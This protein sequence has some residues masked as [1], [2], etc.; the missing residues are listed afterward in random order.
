MVEVVIGVR[1]G[2]HAKSRCGEVLTPDDRARL[3]EAMLED[4][5]EAVAGAPAIGRLWVVTPT[6]ELAR[7]AA[8]R[9][10]EIIHQP[11]DGDLNDA[12]A[13]AL[14]EIGERAPYD[15]VALLPGDLP[16][17][18]PADLEAAF[19]LS[20]THAVVL[21]P[22]LADGGTGA[23][24]LRAGVQLPLFF[25]RDSFARHAA[26]ADRLGLSRAVVI[27]T[28]LTLDLDRPSD[29]HAVLTLGA[30]TRTAA[31]LRTRLPKHLTL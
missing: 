3:T 16:L 27:A 15:S 6:P 19:T 22:A 30:T 18:Q 29:L 8:S 4:M 12:F 21:A 31:F 28:S 2:P 7:L 14:A 25:G 9:G 23:I 5:I 11:Q 24:V 17:L 20:R 26:A 13:L 10:A 1:G